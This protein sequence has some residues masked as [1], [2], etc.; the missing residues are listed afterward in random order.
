MEEF[1]HILAW[2]EGQLYD[3]SG[4]LMHAK[5][6]TFTVVQTRA[7]TWQHIFAFLSAANNP[8]KG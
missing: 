8:K 6:D 4:E 3:V 1:S 7:K 2:V 5:Q